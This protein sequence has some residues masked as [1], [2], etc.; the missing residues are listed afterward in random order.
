MGCRLILQATLNVPERVA[1]LILLDGSCIGAGD[2]IEAEEQSRQH[3]ANVGY[4]AMMES[5]FDAMFVDG[6]DYF[7]TDLVRVSLQPGEATPWME[8]VQQHVPTAALDVIS[9]VGHFPMLEV[10]DIVNN[11]MA[12]FIAG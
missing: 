3:I 9:G 10:P 4:R 5:L 2:P 1:K 7:N 6:A 8:R 12:A 11:K